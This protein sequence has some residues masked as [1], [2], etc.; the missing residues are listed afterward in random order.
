MEIPAETEWATWQSLPTTLAH[1]ELLRK[2]RQG[3]MEQ[4]ASG[5]FDG[6]KF[7]ENSIR[8]AGAIAQIRL[9]EKLLD[10]KYEQ[11]EEAFTDE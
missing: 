8:N 1:R 5:L 3:L 4:W 7:A 6:P 11:L 10:L 2:W 9:I